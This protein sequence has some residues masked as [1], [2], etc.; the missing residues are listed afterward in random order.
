MDYQD[1]D[2]RPPEMARHTM[3]T[4]VYE[5]HHYRYVSDDL[6]EY[7]PLN[8]TPFEKARRFN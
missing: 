1:L 2:T 4:W 3:E 7:P 6:E 5:C 8:P